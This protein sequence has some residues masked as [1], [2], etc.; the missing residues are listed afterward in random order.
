MATDEVSWRNGACNNRSDH[1][2][3]RNQKC[4]PNAKS[5]YSLFATAICIIVLMA[6]N[7]SETLEEMQT[8]RVLSSLLSELEALRLTGVVIGLGRISEE[9]P[10]NST[11]QA[12]CGEEVRV[13]VVGGG[14]CT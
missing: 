1:D 14:A 8:L 13:K 4:D 7:I 2:D 9:R 6:D 11:P 10:G 12:A 5:K 3:D